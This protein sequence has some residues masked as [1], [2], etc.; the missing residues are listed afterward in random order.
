MSIRFRK[1]VKIAKG[2]KVNFSKSGA[3]LSLGGKGHSVNFG[4]RGT[5]VTNGIPG[6]GLSHSTI[7][8]KSKNSGA[9][10]TASSSAS[11]IVPNE[12]D[13]HMNDRGQITFFDGN[14]IEITDKIII[15]KIR[16]LPQFQNQIAQLGEWRRD[17]I[18]R[19]VRDAEIENERFINIYTL[20]PSVES[21]EEFVS[22]FDEIMPEEY[23]ERVYNTPPPSES[24]IREVLKAEAEKAVKGSFLSIGKA[25]KQYV[26]ER[27]FQRYSQALAAWE[28]EKKEFYR[29]QAEEKRIFDREA[30]EECEQKRAFLRD[31]VTG[32]DYAVCEVFDSWI[33]CCELPVEIDVDYDWNQNRKEMM[34]DVELPII[35]DL[36][37]VML[38]KT[39]SGNLKE[40]KKTLTELR[41]EYSRLVFGLAVF[42]SANAFNV[43]P[44]VQKI[45]FSG[46]TKRENNEGK[47]NDEYL[48]S[49][50]FSRSMFEGVDFSRI[51][52]QDF[53]LSTKHR[54]NMTS[55]SLFKAIIPFSSFE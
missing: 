22:R 32:V 25:K 49:L 52:P 11:V 14:G 12:I 41:G 9:R 24:F 7:I 38:I 31:L 16:S 54:C 30:V 35:E 2:I 28:D 37:A 50:K 20:T 44:A 6:T 10:L 8:S 4:S 46:F 55:T 3:S 33:E 17:R 29:Q 45:V 1:T 15:R 21:R 53:C 13:I 23:Q 51:S 5:R 19:L 47:L 48:Y 36:S 40:R 39:D 27:L 42:L 26:E 43:S 18:D 34:L